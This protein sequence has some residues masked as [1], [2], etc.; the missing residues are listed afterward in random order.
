MK[1]TRI[2]RME[3]VEDVLQKHIEATEKLIEDL[4]RMKDA[5]ICRLRIMYLMDLSEMRRNLITLRRK[6]DLAYALDKDWQV[7]YDPMRETIGKMAREAGYDGQGSAGEMPGD[8]AGVEKSLQRR[9]PERDCG[10]G[11]GGSVRTDGRDA[12]EDPED[13]AGKEIRAGSGR[14]KVKRW[15]LEI[16]AADNATYSDGSGLKE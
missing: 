9:Q 3:H 16:M 14:N 4:G 8:C 2:E 5:E 15:Q 1:I 6:L 11:R 13:D 12:A 10:R 7:K